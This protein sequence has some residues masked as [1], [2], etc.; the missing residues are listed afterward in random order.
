[1]GSYGINDKR[2]FGQTWSEAKKRPSFAQELG[3][4]QQFQHLGTENVW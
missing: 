1:M 2:T 3:Q 4:M